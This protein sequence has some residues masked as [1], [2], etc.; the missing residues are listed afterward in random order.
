MSISP[1]PKPRSQTRGKLYLFPTLDQEKFPP[2][3]LRSAQQ[4]DAE[5]QLAL[6]RKLTEAVDRLVAAGNWTEAK[7]SA[8]N[9]TRVFAVPTAQ[10][11]RE[12]RELNDP[13]LTQALLGA[14]LRAAC[15]RG[16]NRAPKSRR[17]K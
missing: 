15:S 14:T 7:R 2:R 3:K 1:T 5:M 9:Q 11:E 4:G 16:T 13:T 17:P 8:G 12:L 6:T 10:V